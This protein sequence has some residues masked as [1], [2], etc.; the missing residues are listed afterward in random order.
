M[1]GERHEA[2]SSPSVALATCSSEQRQHRGK[3]SDPNFNQLAASQHS[4]V[5][6]SDVAL[7]DTQRPGLP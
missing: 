5:L 7:N 6:H 2:V 1:S 3:D 4:V